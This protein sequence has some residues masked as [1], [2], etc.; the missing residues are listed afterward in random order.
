MTHLHARGQKQVRGLQ[1]APTSE[2][3]GQEE[4]ARMD[5]APADRNSWS[6]PLGGVA[7]QA[8]PGQNINIWRTN[9][10]RES[11]QDGLDS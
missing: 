4:P 6:A 9:S 2:L 3:L 7:P 8:N 11:E 1:V 5:E 10:Q